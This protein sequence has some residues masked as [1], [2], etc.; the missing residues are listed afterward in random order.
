MGIG[1]V[2]HGYI[3]CYGFINQPDVKRV[4]RH[5]QRVLKQLPNPDPEW[6]FLP[7]EMFSMLPLRTDQRLGIPQYEHQ[8]IHFAGDY[9]NMYLL[10][11][12]W[13]RKFEQLLS[14]LVWTK[15]VVML[16]FSDLRYEWNVP[17]EFDDGFSHDPPIPP[18]RWTFQSYRIDSTSAGEFVEG[19]LVSPHHIKPKID[20]P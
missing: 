8:I 18:T 20:Q 19:L 16:D 2:I 4:F 9:K 6:P 14:R 3:S 10:Q 12:D 7:R 11:A 15:A 17:P 5:N 13:V 1:V